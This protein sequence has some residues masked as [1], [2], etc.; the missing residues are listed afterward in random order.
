MNAVTYKPMD[1]ADLTHV[2]QVQLDAR[3]G[4]AP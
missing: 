2:V 4:T 1:K 3:M